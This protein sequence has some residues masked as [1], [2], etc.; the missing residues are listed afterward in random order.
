MW[1]VGVALVDRSGHLWSG[2]VRSIELNRAGVNNSHPLV[3]MPT[4]L[5]NA[6]LSTTR[7]YEFGT[8]RVGLGFDRYD[9]RSD[10]DDSEDFRGFVEWQREF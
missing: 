5:V 10:G 3:L 2:H 8:M 9:S 7:E 1:T 4:D 6:E